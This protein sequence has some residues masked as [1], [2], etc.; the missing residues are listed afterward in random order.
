MQK[1]THGKEYFLH[2]L[3]MVGAW[4]QSRPQDLALSYQPVKSRKE[5]NPQSSRLEGVGAVVPKGDRAR[6][7]TSATN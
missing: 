1:G 2:I 3:L 5:Q 7:S 4:P 6:Q